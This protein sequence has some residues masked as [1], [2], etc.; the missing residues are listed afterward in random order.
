MHFTIK[1]LLKFEALMGKNHKII[2]IISKN[3]DIEIKDKK[4][5]SFDE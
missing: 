5:S 2:K 4:W 3:V 1:K